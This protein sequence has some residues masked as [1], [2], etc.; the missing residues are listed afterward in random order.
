VAIA[1]IGYV[2]LSILSRESIAEPLKSKGL[3]VVSEQKKQSHES[4]QFC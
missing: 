2:L 1:I 3:K 4:F